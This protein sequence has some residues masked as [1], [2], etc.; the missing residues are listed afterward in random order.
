MSDMWLILN[1]LE[2]EIDRK[3]DELNEVV[4]SKT[5]EIDLLLSD[6]D[7]IGELHKI[8]ERLSK[9]GLL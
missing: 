4:E 7:K 8:E 2:N 3:I 1:S 9:K 5:H 6:R